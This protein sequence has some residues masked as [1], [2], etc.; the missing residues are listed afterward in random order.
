LSCGASQSQSKLQSLAVNPSNADAQSYPNGEV[1]FTA[2]GYYS[3]PTHTLTPQ[4]AYWVACQKGL[5][6]IDVTVNTAGVAK[7]VG[8]T[9]GAYA[10]NAWDI[11]TGAGVYNC[12]EITACGGGCTIEAAAQLICP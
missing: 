11:P 6:T 7:C 9:A 8:G 12:S 1:P 10:I 4:S 2:T 5:P 3:D